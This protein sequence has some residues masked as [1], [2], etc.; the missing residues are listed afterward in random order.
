MCCAAERRGTVA[1]VR[2]VAGERVRS[3]AWLFHV[4]SCLG[5]PQEAAVSTGAGCHDLTQDR[6]GRLGRGIRADVESRGTGDALELVLFHAS[7]EQALAPALLV[8]PRP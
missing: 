7:L 4:D 1:A 6:E 2:L 3:L 8:S 5:I